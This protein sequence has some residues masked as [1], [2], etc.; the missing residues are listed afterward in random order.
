M[1]LDFV[2]ECGKIYDR[3]G[4]QG[5]DAECMKMVCIL[6]PRVMNPI[7][8]RGGEED[9]APTAHVTIN[10]D[11]DFQD[12]LSCFYCNEEQMMILNTCK[13]CGKH[14]CDR[15]INDAGGCTC[16][17]AEETEVAM[18]NFQPTPAEAKKTTFKK[19]QKRVVKAGADL[20][21]KQDQATPRPSS[22]PHQN[23]Y[24]G[25]LPGIMSQ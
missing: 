17:L 20:V 25:C 10:S 1:K 19:S 15:C 16:Q 24:L 4:E 2:T 12:E 11:V 23:V 13:D 18:M 14:M 3:L 8:F 7:G 5:I 9:I 6:H 22:H 21:L